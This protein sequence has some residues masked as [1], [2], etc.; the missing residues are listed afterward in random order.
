MN[1]ESCDTNSYVP[2]AKALDAAAKAIG[3]NFIGGFS[4]LVD[5]GY[6]KGDRILICL[7]SRSAVR[8]RHSLFLGAIGSTKC[9]INMDAVAE[10]GR[11][12]KAA[13]E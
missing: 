6:T 9:G 8:D 7:H 13:A 11:I 10:M 5:K 1:G 3:V 4:A 12:I 2:L